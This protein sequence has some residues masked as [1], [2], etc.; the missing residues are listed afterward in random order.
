MKVIL[1]EG[2]GNNL[3]P[4]QLQEQQLKE[5]S[6]KFMM[7]LKK[8]MAMISMKKKKVMKLMTSDLQI[9]ILSA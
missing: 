8:N 4:D 2:D 3:R 7:T 1:E 5:K 9:I 6:V